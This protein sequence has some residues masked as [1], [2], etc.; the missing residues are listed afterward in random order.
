[1]TAFTRRCAL[2][3]VAAILAGCATAQTSEKIG[4]NDPAA[5][6]RFAPLT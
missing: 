1:M 3:A 6:P 5:S 2:V 4:P